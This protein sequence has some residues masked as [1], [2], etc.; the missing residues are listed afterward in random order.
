MTLQQQMQLLLNRLVSDG[1]ERG[2]QLTAYVNGKLVVNAWAGVA[3]SGTRQSVD[4]HTL[5]PVF[6]TGK[7]ML[8]TI[9]HRL[10]ERGKL[11][12]DEPI[13][14]VWPEFAAHGKEQITIRQALNHSA[15]I[16]QVPPS[17]GYED[18]HDWDAMCAAV[19]VL[20]PL[21][22]PGTRIEYHAITYGWI[23][24]EV[25]RRI[26]GHSVQ[27]LLRDE[28][29]APLNINDMY[30]GIPDEVESRVASLEE[31]GWQLPT[32]DNPVIPNWIGSLSA[33]MNRPDARRACLPASN[34]IMSAAAIA[35]HYAALLPG[36]VDGIELLSPQRVIT[37]TQMQRPALAQNEDYPKYWGLGYQLGAAGSIYGDTSR[38]FGHAGYG[39]SIGFADPVLGLAL[40]L[41]KNLF[42]KEDTPR[43]IV[44]EL[45]SG[46]KSSPETKR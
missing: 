4:Q 41:T 17:A 37:A 35:R 46:M 43:L 30:M 14:K 11:S 27:T 12:Y 39:G 33:W 31:P 7:G 19:A 9:I 2:L 36:G 22:P 45:R 3:D 10:A 1:T 25:A 40:G 28:I 20:S 34:A 21:W 42:G 44:N 38:A 8:A 16:P 23:L 5:F 32:V 18:F 29:C 24:G 6:S 26:S 15:G 13:A